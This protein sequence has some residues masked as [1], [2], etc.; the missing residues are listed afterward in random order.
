MGGEELML[1]LRM[2]MCEACWSPSNNGIHG[3]CSDPDG[4]K[5]IC[6]C[7]SVSDT[8]RYQHHLREYESSP[9][10]MGMNEV[11]VKS[12]RPRGF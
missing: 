4:S 7:Y 12:D 11:G 10:E 3:R 6:E 9:A 8:H 5:A 2:K 1:G